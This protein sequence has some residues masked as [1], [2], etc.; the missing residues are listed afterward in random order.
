MI[1]YKNGTK[2]Y[3]ESTTSQS[4]R[5]TNEPQPPTVSNT[6]AKTQRENY[7]GS[8][9]QNSISDN[10][11]I[12]INGRMYSYKGKILTTWK[13]FDQIFA[14]NN[15]IQSQ[16]FMRKRK[17]QA[18]AG[19]ALGSVGVVGSLIAVLTEQ[20]FTPFSIISFGMLI[21]GSTLSSIAPKNVAKAINSY[22]SNIEN[23]RVSFK[24]AFKKDKMGN[25]VGLNIRF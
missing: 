23:R 3:I 15:A 4:G 16:Q 11:K 12:D 14:E 25:H 2:E 21:G 5:A 10:E 19:L 20:G 9:N 18:I 24:P 17:T 6:P 7:V 8:T 13:E 1:M 22:N